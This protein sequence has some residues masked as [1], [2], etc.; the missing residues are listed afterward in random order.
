MHR[1]T[2]HPRFSFAPLGLPATEM[3]GRLH[4]VRGWTISLI[5]RQAKDGPQGAAE[6]RKAA[7]SMLCLK[8]G[9]HR[10]VHMHSELWIKCDKRSVERPVMQGAQGNA[11]AGLVGAFG[12][13]GREYVRSVEQPQLNAAHGAALAIGGQ[14]A[15]PKAALSKR[16]TS[17]QDCIAAGFGELLRHGLIFTA[18][19]AATDRIKAVGFL[20]HLATGV[21]RFEIGCIGA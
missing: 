13:R 9:G 19:R 15:P 17:G 11:V 10:L 12:M 4:K 3:V 7:G 6:V 2:A 5:R 18:T 21:E 14:H 16:T 20:R 8:L 1:S